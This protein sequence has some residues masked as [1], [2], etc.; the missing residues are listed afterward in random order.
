MNEYTPIDRNRSADRCE[1][2]VKVVK[3]G[4]EALLGHLAAIGRLK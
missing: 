3:S 4:F 2:T 1:F